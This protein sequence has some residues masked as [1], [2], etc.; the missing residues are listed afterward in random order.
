MIL[1]VPCSGLMLPGL[2]AIMGPTGSGKTTLLD[3]L[4]DRKD[5]S[6]LSGT[7]LINGRRKPPNYK[8]AVGY[9]V[10]DDVVMGTLSVRENLHFSAA[11]RLPSQMTCAERKERVER[12]IDELGLRGCASTKVGTEFLRGVSGGE[13]K[14]TNIGME[15]IIEPQLLFLDEPTTGLD[16][17]TAV[18]VVKLLKSRR[19]L[20][21]LSFSIASC[22][23]DNVQTISVCF[24]RMS[25]HKCTWSVGMTNQHA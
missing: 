15:L 12:V 4:A 10:Q 9:V 1:S 3:I 18:S 13:R 16:A 25:N 14:R 17:Y 8:C 11:L 2:N 23:F 6:G 19:M 24:P 7:V 21:F 22:L 5:K 20:G